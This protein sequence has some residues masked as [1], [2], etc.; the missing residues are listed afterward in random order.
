MEEEVYSGPR[1]AS[2]GRET[3]TYEP[4]ATT[5]G[6]NWILPIVLLAGVIGLIWYFGSRSQQTAFVPK[7]TV[8][9]AGEEGSRGPALS[10][11]ELKVKY[12]SAIREAQIQGIRISDLREKDGKLVMKGMAPSQRAVNKV[13]DEIKRVDTSMSDVMV[14]ITAPVSSE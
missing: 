13:W 14:N 8:H 2:R 9:A 1:I 3:E 11:R 7:P 5:T 6:T 10:L 4:S 12:A